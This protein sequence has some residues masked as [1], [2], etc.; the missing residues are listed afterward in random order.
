MRVLVFRK[1]AQI[2]SPLENSLYV[3]KAGELRARMLTSDGIKS[4]SATFPAAGGHFGGRGTSKML[5]VPR[6]R[7]TS[8]QSG[9]AVYDGTTIGMKDLTG[10]V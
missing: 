1:Q 5:Y 9:S 8:K 3:G 4:C 10:H 7:Y 6:K 2:Q